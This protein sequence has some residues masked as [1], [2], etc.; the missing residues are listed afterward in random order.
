MR[1]SLGMSASHERVELRL[2][3]D[4]DQGLYRMREAIRTNMIKKLCAGKFDRAKA[5]KGFKYLTDEAARKYTKEFGSPG[6]RIFSVADRKAVA[7]E[8]AHELV[9]AVNRFRKG[10]SD[11]L[12]TK[13]KV[14]LAKKTCKVVRR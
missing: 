6:S 11:D 7:K 3:A 1:Q 2:Y 14:L 8:Y 10:R 4:N 12:S 5:A 13:Q 9:A